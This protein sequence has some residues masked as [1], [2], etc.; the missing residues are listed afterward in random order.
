M[1]YKGA[2]VW[3]VLLLASGVV[4]LQ[5]LQ[6]SGELRAVTDALAVT[7]V[8]VIGAVLTVL[9]LTGAIVLVCLRSVLHQPVT[10]NLRAAATN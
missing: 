3:T 1:H 2:S 7:P 10:Q 8:H 5:L 4:A 6:R 9:L